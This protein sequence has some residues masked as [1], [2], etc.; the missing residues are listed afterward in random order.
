M[1]SLARSTA[2]IVLSGLLAL[3]PALAAQQ[4]SSDAAPVPPEILHA[5]TVFVA[6]RGGSNYFQIFSGGPNRAYNTF[7][8]ELKRMGQY[9][10]VSSPAQADLIFEIRAIAP[11]V[12]GVNDIPTYNPQVILTIRDPRTNVALWTESANV[13]ALGTKTRRDRQFDQSVAVLVDKLAQVTGQPLTSAQTKAVATNS[14][15]S[16]PTAVKVFMVA[17]IAGAAAFTAWAIHK[18]NNPPTLTPP[19]LPAQP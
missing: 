10:L 3:S 6:N 18:A 5:H 12:S 11:E 4:T 1:F 14:N 9:E 7:Y 13:R 17:S 8:K 16:M 19:T 2:S 15:S